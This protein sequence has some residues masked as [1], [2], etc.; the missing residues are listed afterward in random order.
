MEVVKAEF[1][2]RVRQQGFPME[3]DGVGWEV[4]MPVPLVQG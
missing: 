4:Q 3:G 2:A 1:Q